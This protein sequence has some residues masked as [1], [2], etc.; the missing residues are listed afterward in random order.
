MK[1]YGVG[2]SLTDSTR[3][4]APQVRPCCGTGQD[5]FMAQRCS[6]VRMRPLL[7]VHHPRGRPRRL[8]VS[9]AVN[10]AAV[11]T[12][13]HVSLRSRVWVF[14][15]KHPE[16]GSLGP[17]SSHVIAF[18][19]KSILS[20]ISIATLAFLFFYFHEL[21]FPIPFLPVCVCQGTGAL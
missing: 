11:D 2:L 13:G 3:H 21:S 10:T 19:I 15:D 6:G 4:S 17:A 1:S 5:F 8:H 18:V 12:W 20:G 9:A 7:C 14:P 16:V